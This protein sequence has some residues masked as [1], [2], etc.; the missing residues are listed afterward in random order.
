[1]SFFSVKKCVCRNPEELIG[2]GVLSFE[3]NV[4]KI[5]GVVPYEIALL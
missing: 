1:M 4:M 5:G 2:H 3:V